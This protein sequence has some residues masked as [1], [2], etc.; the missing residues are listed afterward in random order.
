MCI[1]YIYIY[2]ICIN[3]TTLAS[4]IIITRVRARMHNIMHTLIPLFGYY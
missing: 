2:I 3:N 1:I 4:S